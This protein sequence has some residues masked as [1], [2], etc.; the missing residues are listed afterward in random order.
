MKN[1]T[2]LEELQQRIIVGDGAFGTLLYE[3]G[4]PLTECYDYLNISNPELVRQI[5]WEYLAAGAEVIETN[6][7]GANRWKLKHYELA[8]SVRDITQRGAEIALKCAGD[9]AWV[10]GSIGPLGRTEQISVSDAEKTDIFREHAQ[11]LLDGGVELIILETFH[12][13]S[14]VLLALHVVKALKNLPVITQLMLTDSGKTL[15]GEDALPAFFKLKQAGADVVGVN[16]GIG[17]NGLLKVLKPIASKI[18]LPVSAF[19][20]A[21]FPERRD[22]RLMYLMS[23][24]YLA[25]VAGELV[26]AGVNLIGGCCGT[27]PQE[28][29]AIKR[30]VAGMRPPV[31]QPVDMQPFLDVREQPSPCASLPSHTRLKDLFRQKKVLSVEL[32]PPKTFQIDRVLAG[33]KAVQAA[34]ADVINIAEN[35]LAVVRLSNT[36]LARHIQQAV[37]IETVVH[38]TCRDRNLLGLQSDLMGMALDGLHNVL[39]ITG[40]PPSKGNE[41]HVKGVYDLRSFELIALLTKLNQGQNYFGEDLKCQTTFTIGAALNPNVTRLEVQVERMWKKIEAGAHFFQT[42]PVY[43]KEKID[44]ILNVTHNV[45]APILLGILPLVSFRNAEFLHNEFPGI[46]IPDDI[47]EKM[48]QA[49]E[50]GVEQGIEIAWELITYAYPHFAGIYLMP[51]FNKYQIAVELLQ[52]I[53]Q[54]FTP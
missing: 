10:A 46:S 16:C 49:G 33:A 47:R 34:G 4:V 7:F 15:E 50:R 20:N 23:P 1:T 52:R 44:Q 21:G 14:D 17:P 13:L 11:G 2:F 43:S 41:E 40:D 51:P 53:V 37:G 3:K 26:K 12:S 42:Q 6:T 5:H 45:S 48:R 30:A 25:E 19:P 39:A 28:I 35:P 9:A 8:E 24:D 54:H 27:G 29:R 38:L 18:D 32:D 31:K 36:M 22:D